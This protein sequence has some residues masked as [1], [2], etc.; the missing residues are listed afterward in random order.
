[1]EIKMV[2]QRSGRFEGKNKLWYKC[3]REQYE[4]N[5]R[6]HSSS[7][8]MDSPCQL[9]DM[10]NPLPYILLPL[11]LKFVKDNTSRMKKQGKMM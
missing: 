6:L 3:E 2:D 5:L 1:K 8:F 7:P 4:I 11:V 10:V 9:P